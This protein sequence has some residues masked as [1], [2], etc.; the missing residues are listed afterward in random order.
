VGSVELDILAT[1]PDEFVDLLTQDLRDIGQKVFQTGISGAR[2]FRVIE[3]GE[4][5]GTREGD[6]DDPR[7]PSA[8]EGELLGG[9]EATAAQ[10]VEDSD[11]WALD[12]LV[13]H[14]GAVPVA[15]QERVEI[16]VAEA[17]DRLGELALE[18]QAAHLAVRDHGKSRVFLQADRRIDR[19][20]LDALEL[21]RTDLASVP[22][23]P[24]VEQLGRPEKA[25]DYV[26][27]RHQ[28][29]A[30]KLPVPKAVKETA[31]QP[32]LGRQRW[33]GCW[34]GAKL[35][36]D[37]LVVV[38]PGDR[39]NH[40]GLVEVFGALNNGNEADEDTVAHDLCFKARCAVGVPHRLST[41]RKR[42]AHPALVLAG[43]H[44][45]CVHTALAQ[46]VGDPARPVLVH[47]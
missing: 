19:G 47:A 7:R 44:Q 11:P 15:P 27:T 17:L 4:Q 35:A 40:L 36:R 43:P 45:M 3:V 38:S 5:A 25:A 39:V 26:G 32:A 8:R 14:L 30:R 31:E 23:L 24:G 20:I 18:R 10:P 21:G 46:R 13:A 2:A 12:M 1:E 33:T 16:P 41:A 9:E 37:R 34:R 29:G 22:A 6:F 42:Y 28:H